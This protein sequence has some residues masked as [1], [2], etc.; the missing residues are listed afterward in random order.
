MRHWFTLTAEVGQTE[1]G[2]GSGG[3]G[4]VLGSFPVKGPS[5]RHF[6]LDYFRLFYTRK[7]SSAD[8]SRIVMLDSSQVLGFF[9]SLNYQTH[10]LSECVAI[11]RMSGHRMKVLL[12]IFALWYSVDLK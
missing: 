11:D 7:K 9:W 5:G 2:D 6:I 8:N 4:S 12:W 10:L 3:A 1:M